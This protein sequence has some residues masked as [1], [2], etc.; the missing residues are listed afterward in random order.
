MIAPDHVTPA[1]AGVHSLPGKVWT[2]GP[3]LWMPACAGMTVCEMRG[4][5]S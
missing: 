1:K 5:S 2:A 4:T 3:L